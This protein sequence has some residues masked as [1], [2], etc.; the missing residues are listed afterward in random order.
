MPH[1]SLRHSPAPRRFDHGEPMGG[2]DPRP[3]LLMALIVVAVFLL[4]AG[5]PRQHA[6]LVELPPPFFGAR[7][8]SSEVIAN[9]VSITG[10]GQI[11]WNG[12]PVSTAEFVNLLKPLKGLDVQP[13]LMFEPDGDAPY[14]AAASTLSLIW[15]AGLVDEAFCFRGLEKHQ[16]FG[17]AALPAQ[18]PNSEGDPPDWLSDAAFG[19]EPPPLYTAP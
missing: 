12:W 10:E 14:G 18:P 6:L 13:Y 8:T 19:C 4:A 16:T 3:L 2:I 9:R 17:K 11:M 1:P 5:K 7:T 15:R